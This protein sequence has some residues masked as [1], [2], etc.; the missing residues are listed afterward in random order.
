MPV[1]IGS[2]PTDAHGFQAY[3]S[4]AVQNTASTA[5]VYTQSLGLA[6]LPGP[7]GR[8][9]ISALAQ[10]VSL[11]T[12]Q[13]TPLRSVIDA[14]H[15]QAT[16][17]RAVLRTTRVFV[18]RPQVE[19]TYQLR[20]AAGNVRV[21]M[22]G[23]SVTFTLAIETL[24]YNISG[25][26]AVSCTPPSA[27]LYLGTC[28]CSVQ[29]EPGSGTWDGL[30]TA[31]AKLTLIYNGAT[32]LTDVHAEN[33][34][35]LV[36]KPAWWPNG[37][38]VVNCQ[39]RPTSGGMFAT[40]RASPSYAGEKLSVTVY[41]H[42]GSYPLDSF[43]ILV[44]YDTLLLSYD[45]DYSQN[46][47][48]NSAVVVQSSDGTGSSS[49]ASNWIVFSVVGT[50]AGTSDQSVTGEEL[51]LLMVRFSVR[52]NGAGTLNSP[53]LHPSALRVHVDDMVNT[54]AVRF[55]DNQEATLFGY[56]DSGL[57]ST[58]AGLSLVAPSAT[59][60]FAFTQSATLTNMAPIDGTA[61][62][63]HP[64]TA[65]RVY[66]QLELGATKV[67]GADATALVCT[68]S[69]APS[70]LQLSGCTVELSAAQ[71]TNASQA[72]VSV[73]LDS[74][75][76]V[77]P[78][79]IWYPSGVEL[80]AADSLL[81]RISGVGACGAPVYQQTRISV[82]VDGMDAGGTA[83]LS[84]FD[85]SV[86][87]IEAT[88][89]ARGL[90]AGN[91][92]VFLA[93][94]PA[95]ATLNA[96]ITVS[97]VA[98]GVAELRSRLITSASWNGSLPSKL[99]G[100][101]LHSA[102]GF[103]V[104][105]SLR[106]QLTAE[107]H[108]GLLYTIATFDD[109]ESQPV[110]SGNGSVLN[111]IDE[112]PGSLR[113]HA[114]TSTQP[115]WA[116]EVAF[117]AT[118]QCGPLITVEWRACE[119]VLATGQVPVLL[120]IPSPTEC[121]VSVDKPY[122][123]AP[124]D[125]AALPPVNR[126]TSSA[127][128]V[129]VFFDDNTT[130]DFTTDPRTTWTLNRECGNLM[131]S[132]ARP[133]VSSMDT[134]GRCA[135]IDLSATVQFDGAFGSV[136]C[137][138][139]LPMVFA[140][141]LELRLNSY[142]GGT[143][144]PLSHPPS[145]P[146]DPPALPPPPSAPPPLPPP[147]SPPPPSP[148][149]SPPSLPPY[150]PAPPAPPATPPPCMPPLPPTAPP[151][152]LPPPLSPPY[153]PLLPPPSDAGRRL[154]SEV[155]SKASAPPSAAGRVLA[156]LGTNAN[157]RT[158]L[159]SSPTHPD[160]MLGRVQ[161]TH[162]FHH[163]SVEA[164]LPLSNGERIDVT[165]Q[166]SQPVLSNAS[167]AEMEGQR[168]K[169]LA[170]GAVSVN[171]TF[172]AHS[173]AELLLHVVDLMLDPITSI[174]LRLPD[175]KASDT[176]QA[177]LYGTLDAVVRLDFNSGAVVDDAI[178]DL[179]WIPVRTLLAFH[180]SNTGVVSVSDYGTFTLQDNH[181]E[182]IELRT[183]LACSVPCNGAVPMSSLSIAANLAAGVGDV[184]LGSLTGLQF[185]QSGDTLAIG[186]YAT[187]QSG[188]NLVGFQVVLDPLD[189]SYLTS[190]CASG[191]SPCAS[192]APSYTGASAALNNPSSMAQVQAT[193][194]QSTVSGSNIHLGTITLPVVG[195]GVT[196]LQGQIVTMTTCQGGDD[197][198]D[199]NMRIRQD[200]SPIAAGQG[201]VLLTSSRRRRRRM[202]QATS[203][204]LTVLPDEEQRAAVRARRASAI[205]AAA[206]RP[207]VAQRRLSG[208]PLTAPTD[209]TACSM[210]I[211]AVRRCEWRRQV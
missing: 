24:Q 91:T 189:E 25:C 75:V 89:I 1:T 204:P 48:Y 40:L 199:A 60:L 157:N 104:S 36:A 126:P 6:A 183:S 164:H 165:N 49:V 140:Q 69:S 3:T 167:V 169:V 97:D 180:S 66:D 77:V 64:I 96:T 108:T 141:P 184:D 132:D 23:L 62:S 11:T 78:L 150:P 117:G 80:L 82:M 92:T 163:A 194:L 101:A 106:Q 179:D 54:G 20:D 122:L 51:Q 58:T 206:V 26:I 44:Y 200:L 135:Q 196:L 211:A 4:G 210:P 114:P 198:N 124:S 103:S 161:G 38:C 87:V 191:G 113:F 53:T 173:R 182:R 208:C 155:G 190:G 27:P 65:A 203:A 172:G 31:V 131:S 118:W 35:S 71:T 201:Y 85:G 17:L 61:A 116:V 59:G 74:L 160:Y 76:A 52:S 8:T 128:H 88:N 28:S 112:R 187:T 67:M 171:A 168:V 156:E 100:D 138:M 134:N 99:W 16:T 93:L 148:P 123:V 137:K 33:E 70:A 151:P 68:S 166:L 170:A 147:P 42:T 9:T 105:V 30:G 15:P 120:D 158:D 115:L 111:L 90:A 188:Y 41:A 73:S 46:Q 119:T 7:S 19:V 145:A 102:D 154:L 133:I 10:G 45:S 202:S 43:T 22:S 142:P 109:G 162:H 107:G 2:A 5:D 56:G 94:R 63:S 152:L 127:L 18:D 29:D 50:T 34:L 81:S 13:G 209:A 143:S 129:S 84:I 153:P 14:A 12:A 185:T 125:D 149:P 47:D 181:Y 32:I 136:L 39:S 130:S 197:C 195:S 139:A 86:A 176:M 110:E 207:R 55:I 192:F 146:P 175:L 205:A 57:G 193:D 83:S 21:T 98:I 121:V 174:T 159:S 72:A 144:L 186:M 95:L 37:A 177:Q 79:Q 178:K